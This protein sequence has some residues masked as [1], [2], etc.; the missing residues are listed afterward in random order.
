LIKRLSKHEISNVVLTTASMY[1]NPYLPEQ[2]KIDL[3]EAYGG[4]A[5]GEQELEGRLIEQ[6]PS[7]LWTRERVA[8]NRVAPELV[9]ELTKITV[10]VDPSGGAG[11]QGIVVAG[12]FVEVIHTGSATTPTR[13]TREMFTLADY[14]CNLSPAQWGARA[15][16]AAVDWEADDIVVETNYGGD[17]AVS[18]IQG[19][20]EHAGLSIPVRKIVATRG[21]R[22][23]AE[24]V[25]ALME[26]DHD[27]HAGV[28]EHL[29]DQMCTWTDDAGYSPDRVDAKVW[30]A[31]HLKLVSTAR[32]TGHGTFGGRAA[33]ES[34]I[35]RRVVG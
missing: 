25:A 20:V 33:T 21:K 22:V 29:E 2:I 24:P 30:C 26:R 7:A 34:V 12:S 14:S 13:T 31:W 6:D 8:R 16:Q 9:P 35:G 5:L 18:T 15:V 23:R 4:T 19:A 11:E 10:G 3:E 28:F 32:L 1:D 27:H 17:M